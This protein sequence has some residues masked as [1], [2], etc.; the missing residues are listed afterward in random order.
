LKWGSG[1][2]SCSSYLYSNLDPATKAR[3]IKLLLFCT[4]LGVCWVMGK[5]RREVRFEMGIWQEV[6]F[7]MPVLEPGPCKH[8]MKY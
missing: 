3:N 1:R 6:L 8:G 7:V 4:M 5:E 2:R